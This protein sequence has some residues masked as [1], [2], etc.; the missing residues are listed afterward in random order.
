V[1]IEL[2]MRMS[3]SDIGLYAVACDGGNPGAGKVGV[4]MGGATGRSTRSGLSNSA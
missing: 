2:G 1:R 4:G 3:R